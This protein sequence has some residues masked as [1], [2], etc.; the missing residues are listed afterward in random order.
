MSVLR[1]MDMPDYSRL[2]IGHRIKDARK[3]ADL[4]QSELAE[5]TGLSSQHISNIETGRT[6]VSLVAFV[7]IANALSVSADSL[8]CDCL[9]VGDETMSNEIQH[10]VA[11]CCNEELGIV[12]QVLLHAIETVRNEID[13]RDSKK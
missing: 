11:A 9:V 4:S 12:Q 10:L 13:R 5:R 8:L 1:G 7:D 6:D 3:A 2:K